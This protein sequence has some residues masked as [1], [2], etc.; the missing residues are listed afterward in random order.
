ME[1]CV[2]LAGQVAWT[3]LGN[4]GELTVTHDVGF[5]IVLVECLQ[6]FEEGML[7]FLSSRVVG[8]SFLVETTFVADTD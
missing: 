3:G 6:Q 8:F 2:V 7:L 5:G 4:A 1:V